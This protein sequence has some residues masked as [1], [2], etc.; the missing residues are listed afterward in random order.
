MLVINRIRHI[1]EV[2]SQERCSETP[3]PE[4]LLV[5]RSHQSGVGTI[6]DLFSMVWGVC[7]RT[8]SRAGLC[9]WP[10]AGEKGWWLQWRVAH[11]SRG[12]TARLL[13][14]L[15]GLQAVLISVNGWRP[16]ASRIIAR[17]DGKPHFKSGLHLFL[18]LA[19]TA[20]QL[21]VPSIV[22]HGEAAGEV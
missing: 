12:F 18:T 2:P 20:W 7:S 5:S 16:Q 3:P 10:A 11:V 1:R 14:R 8:L 6:F 9:H 4:K 13:E 17:R 21:F 22:D 19:P 15:T